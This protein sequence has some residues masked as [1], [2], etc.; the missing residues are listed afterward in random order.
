[1]T[2]IVPTM[3]ALNARSFDFFQNVMAGPVPA[4]TFLGVGV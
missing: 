2:L 3:A 4:M 1:M